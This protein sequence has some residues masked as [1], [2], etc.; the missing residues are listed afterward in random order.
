MTRL[1]LHRQLLVPSIA[2]KLSAS[3]LHSMILISV[4]LAGLGHMS[5]SDWLWL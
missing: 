3:M 4:S 2:G 5:W 1:I